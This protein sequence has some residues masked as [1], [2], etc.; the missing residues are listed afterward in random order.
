MKADVLLL[1]VLMAGLFL[2]GIIYSYVIYLGEKGKY[3]EGFRWL[4]VIVGVA[5]PVIGV[6]VLD[7]MMALKVFMLFAAAGTP[8]VL[9]CIYQYVT[10]RKASQDAIKK[11][12][13]RERRPE[14]LA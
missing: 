8:V 9:F 3:L 7:W 11:E 10:K 14:T 4:A 6:A 13:D 2:F 1:L 5:V 12:V